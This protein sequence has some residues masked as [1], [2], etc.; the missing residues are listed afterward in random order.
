[1]LF[2]HQGR[3]VNYLR[4][5]VTDRCNLRCVYCM[6]AGGLEWT[7]RSRLLSYEEMLRLCTLLVSMGIEKI[8]ITGGEPFMRKDMM[9]FLNNL[10]SIKGLGQLT[11]TTNGVR[12]ASLVP[13]LKK[14][15]V[16]IVNLSL[17]TLDREQFKSIT[18]RD[19]LPRVLDT[20]DQLL[21]HNIE[22]RINVV[23]M[24]GKNTD[25][26]ISMVQ[27]TKDLPVS[28]RFIE[29]M[30]FNGK[31]VYDP[32]NHWSYPRILDH[33]KISF[34]SIQKIQD[35][36]YSTSYNYHIP[37]HKGNIGIIA[38]YSRTFCGTCN[39]IRITPQG[40]LKTCLYDQGGTDL[41]GLM[42]SGASD[43][44][45]GNAIQD[46]LQHKVKDGW[47]A[48]RKRDPHFES[49]AEIGG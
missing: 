46:A 42:R 27:L 34:P 49:M 2:D 17:D 32:D 10:S 23:V 45:I 40:I 13:D 11:L 36:P 38:A 48:E 41:K 37:E 30:P 16:R 29:E 8:R 33:I 19:E 12:T 9:P 20:L 43:E 15:G 6:P 22:V 26:I 3:K 39:R 1:M 24:E 5:A 35:P 31:D 18:L 4:L 14:A 28:V 7:E 25:S 47:E 44:E 21:L